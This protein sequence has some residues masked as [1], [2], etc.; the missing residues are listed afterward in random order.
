MIIIVELRPTQTTHVRNMKLAYPH[1][2][3]LP[4]QSCKIAY[5]LI[6]QKTIQIYNKPWFIWHV[7]QFQF[8]SNYNSMQRK[9]DGNSDL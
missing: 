5:K 6:T 9:W 1:Y 7:Q 2:Y 4:S 3:L 8:K